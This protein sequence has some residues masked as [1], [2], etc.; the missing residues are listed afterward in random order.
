MIR[1]RLLVEDFSFWVM[2]VMHA[3][4]TSV[5]DVRL[6][7]Y[8]YTH[9]TILMTSIYSWEKSKQTEEKF[10]CNHNPP[11]LPRSRFPC[12]FEMKYYE[13]CYI[14]ILH[15]YILREKKKKTRR[16]FPPPFFFLG[17]CALKIRFIDIYMYIIYIVLSPPK[18]QRRS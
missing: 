5:L 18:V 10:W 1:R 9:T 8:L 3:S 7:L 14:I 6:A 15:Y 4:G 2:K 11:S 13:L 12:Y 17:G 16:K